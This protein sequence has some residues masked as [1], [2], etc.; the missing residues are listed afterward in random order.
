MI[1]INVDA[2]VQNFI[3]QNIPSVWPTLTVNSTTPSVGNSISGN[4][5]TANTSA[6]T[7][8][9][10][11]NGY[12]GQQITVVAGDS[13]TTIQHNSALILKG[14]VNFVMAAGNTLTLIKD[15]NLWREI[16]R[17]S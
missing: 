1:Q 6:T 4:F 17:T 8:T 10:F 3:W 11:N 9:I 2:D 12:V 13:N 16:S 5:Y 7:I 15:T 14:S